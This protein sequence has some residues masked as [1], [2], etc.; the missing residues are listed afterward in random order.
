MQFI[1]DAEVLRN[2]RSI[3]C[4]TVCP[5]CYVI[6]LYRW[7]LLG[8]KDTYIFPLLVCLPFSWIY[9]ALIRIWAYFCVSI[10][11]WPGLIDSFTSQHDIFDITFIA[12]SMHH[13]IHISL[14]MFLIN[15]ERSNQHF[16]SAKKIELPF[17]AANLWFFGEMFFSFILYQTKLLSHTANGVKKIIDFHVLFP[18][19]VFNFIYR[20]WLREQLAA[21]IN[22]LCT[23]NVQ[24]NMLESQRPEKC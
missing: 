21:E 3:P 7:L 10:T 19:F 5:F 11:L 8:L 2:I 4:K 14:N 20:W 9:L 24:G 17:Q 12:N 15:G 16:W 22:F 23:Q 1:G 13:F 18:I 6:V